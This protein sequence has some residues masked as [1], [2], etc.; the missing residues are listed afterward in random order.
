NVL[1]GDYLRLH[2]IHT[3]YGDY[4]NRD[5]KAR[6]FD[7]DK[8]DEYLQATGWQQR[9][10]DGIRVKDGM[11]LSFTVTYGVPDHT[12]RLILLK[13]EAKKAGIELKLE[14]LDS[15]ASFK[16]I[17]EKKHDIAWMGWSTGLRPAYWQHFHSD[18]AHKTQTNNITNTDVPELDSLITQYRAAV[19]EADRIRLARQIQRLIHAQAMYIPTYMAPYA[20]TAYWAWLSL[21]DFYGTRSSGSLFDPFGAGGSGGLFWIDQAKKTSLE[22]AR[23]DGRRFDPVVIK[24]ETYKVTL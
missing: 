2:N 3:G 5:I 9:G 8:V 14:L 12:D 17:L 11:R 7:L 19:E 18:N 24:D 16:K 10:A 20:R 1:R 21:P 23:K 4:T 15:S 6:G 22:Q 13:E